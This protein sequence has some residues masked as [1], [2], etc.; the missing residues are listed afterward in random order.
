MNLSRCLL[1]ACLASIFL[2]LFAS[3]SRRDVGAGFLPYCGKDACGQVESRKVAGLGKG[4]GS[5]GNGVSCGRE[6]LI[7]LPI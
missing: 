5:C 7:I 4:K 6:K 3:P 2:L 1:A